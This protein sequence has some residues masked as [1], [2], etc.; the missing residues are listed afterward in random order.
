VQAPTERPL[1][2]IPV[3]V[4]DLDISFNNLV[5]LLVKIALAAIP[6]LLILLIVGALTLAII[7]SLRF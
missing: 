3:V 1:R 2:S 7:G 6:A 4:T 5:W